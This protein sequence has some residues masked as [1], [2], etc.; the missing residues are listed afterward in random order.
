MDEPV[1]IPAGGRI[2][3]AVHWSVDHAKKKIIHLEVNIAFYAALSAFRSITQADVG[4]IANEIQAEWSDIRYKCYTLQTK[5]NTV[6]CSGPAD[7]PDDYID[8]ALLGFLPGM[9]AFTWTTTTDPSKIFS[10]DP[11][12]KGVPVRGDPDGPQSVWPVGTPTYRPYAHEFGHLIG[13]DDGYFEVKVEGD[14]DHPLVLK[15]PCH[16]NDIMVDDEGG[17]VSSELVTQVVRRSG[18]PDVA[19]IGPCP[20]AFDTNTTSLWL[21]LAELKEFEIHARCEDI[22]PPADGDANP[23]KPMTFTGTV[24]FLGGYLMGDDNA[25]ARGA[26]EALGVPAGPLATD[27]GTVIPVTFTLTPATCAQKD[28]GELL[29]LVIA[30]PNLVINGEYH[31]SA[32]GGCPVLKGPLVVNGLPTASWFP[33]PALTGKFSLPDH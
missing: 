6:I 8:I 26:L 11:G 1:T 2:T 29:T 12:D 16:T 25:D 23:P 10:G 22:E 24:S 19:K 20:M 28:S 18:N 33:G 7:A 9:R 17:H 30:L 14:E 5:V 32:G 15:V 4:A 27:H 21:L 31:W 3:D 13:A